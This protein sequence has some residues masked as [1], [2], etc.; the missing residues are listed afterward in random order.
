M[1]ASAFWPSAVFT[2]A[3]FASPASFAL[4]V[5]RDTGMNSDGSAKFSDPDD[6]KPAFM[7][8]MPD[9][10]SSATQRPSGSVTVSPGL[11]GSD[12]MRSFNPQNSGTDAFDQAYSHK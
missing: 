12:N 5:D 7:N 3:L 6:Q 2:L 1:R 9:E 11:T 10:P 4:S 8:G